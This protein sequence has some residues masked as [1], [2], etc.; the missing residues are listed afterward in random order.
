MIIF[1]YLF[2][3]KL[4]SKKLLFVLEI[5]LVHLAQHIK[6][7]AALYYRL[8]QIHNMRSHIP[9]IPVQSKGT[10]LKEDQLSC[11]LLA[12]LNSLTCY[13]AEHQAVKHFGKA[14]VEQAKTS[15]LI[16]VDDGMLWGAG[17]V[18]HL[19]RAGRERIRNGHGF[20]QQH[21]TVLSMHWFRRI[22]ERR[23]PDG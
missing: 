11:L 23:S 14:T 6:V 5:A 3:S 4:F 19:T 12:I 17:Q 2:F 10:G 21:R 9:K 22:V 8:D 20:M 13:I 7:Y 1:N 15:G 16:E 18:L